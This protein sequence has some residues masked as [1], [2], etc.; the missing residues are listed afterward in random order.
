MRCDGGDL[1]NIRASRASIFNIR[2]SGSEL[3][4][5][6]GEFSREHTGMRLI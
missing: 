1:G 2:L 3:V 6:D 5:T 4:Q